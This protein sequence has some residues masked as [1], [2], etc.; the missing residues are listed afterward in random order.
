MNEQEFVERLQFLRKELDTVDS[1]LLSLLNRRAHVSI[2]MGD[3]QK[4]TL[5]FDAPFFFEPLREKEVLEALVEKNNGPLPHNH[6]CSIWRELFS[7]SRMLQCPQSV[8][9]LGPE[10]TF[11]YFAGVEYL[12]TC[13]DF[14]P[15]TSFHDV[16][17]AVFEEQCSLGIIPLENSLQGTMGQCFDL[18]YKFNV[19]I[20]AEVLL[21]I[22]YSLMSAHM[23]LTDIKYVYSNQQTLAQCDQWLRTHIPWAEQI[24]VK[25]TADAARRA[26][27]EQHSA[28]IGHAK[29]AVMHALN[30][31]ANGLETTAD[32]WTRYVVIAPHSPVNPLLPSPLP[33]QH[34]CKNNVEIKT[35]ILFTLYDKPGSLGAV[36]DIFAASN[37]NVRTLESRPLASNRGEAWRYVFFVDVEQDLCQPL[38]AHVIEGLQNQCDSVSILGAYTTLKPFSML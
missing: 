22:T 32:N 37:I 12:G 31:L 23:L 18:F 29:L 28:A 25:S 7:S 27:E 3:L 14:R 10:G 19:T 5:L 34:G 15:Y 2:E 20:R 16:F 38:Y 26:T 11:S 30:T 36:L 8:A 24:P 21:R 9:Y 4:K 35:S 13:V 6:L 1:E 17:R 33:I